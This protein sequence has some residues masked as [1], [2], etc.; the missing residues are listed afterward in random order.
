MFISF[1]FSGLKMNR[2]VAGIVSLAVVLSLTAMPGVHSSLD[3]NSKQTN[4]KINKAIAD[5][6]TLTRVMA[7]KKGNCAAPKPSYRAEML[8]AVER[9]YSTYP[10]GHTAKST[11]ACL[12]DAIQIP[13]PERAYTHLVI[14][15]LPDPVHTSLAL[16]FDRQIDALQQGAQDNGWIFDE[17]KMPWDNKDHPESSDPN[18]RKLAESYQGAAEEQPGFLMFHH[19]PKSDGT[20]SRERL[21]VFVVGETPTGGVEKQQF[22]NA[23]AI[24]QQ[25]F[26][27][28][29]KCSVKYPLGPLP[30]LGPTFS[31][32][33]ASLSQLLKC[34]GI[35][36]KINLACR[37]NISIFS[38]TVTDRLSV[39]AFNLT[40]GKN[41]LQTLQEFDANSIDRL[42]AFSQKRSYKMERIA[43]LSE[44]ETAYGAS[45]SFSQSRPPCCERNLENDVAHFYFPRE[46]SQLRNAYQHNLTAEPRRDKNQSTTLPLDLESNGSDDDTV[47]QYSRNQLPLSQESVLL[48]IVA[49][50]RKHNSELVIIRATDPFDQLFLARFLRQAYPQG[51]IITVGA[52]LLFS[53]EVQDARLHGVIALSTYDLTPG[54]GHELTPSGEF[55]SDRVFP[56]SYSMGTYNAM[57]LLLATIPLKDGDSFE[58][59]HASPACHSVLTARLMG[60]RDT[61]DDSSSERK[62]TRPAVHL[63]VLGHEGFW[64]LASLPATCDENLPPVCVPEAPSCAVIA[65]MARLP[66]DWQL[67]WLL[68]IFI[69]IAYAY[70]LWTASIF[71]TSE[72]VA[73]LAPPVSDSR[74]VLLASTG[75]L[76]F[77]LL[78]AVSLPYFFYKHHLQFFVLVLTMIVILM[79]CWADL[80]RRSA[81]RF[82]IFCFVVA[83][84]ATSIWIVLLWNSGSA[85]ELAVPRS[86]TLSSGVSPLLPLLLLLLGGLWSAWYSLSGASLVGSHCPI[87]PSSGDIEGSEIKSRKT[88]YPLLKDSQV[89]LKRL[90]NPAQWDSS[91]VVAAVL[92]ILACRNFA[93]T[94]PFRTLEGKGYEL[95]LAVLV[96]SILGFLVAGVIRLKGIWV[97]LHVLLESLNLLGLGSGFKRLTG[98][99]W[100]PL[101]RLSPGNRLVLRKLVT[102]QLETATKIDQLQ[103]HGFISFREELEKHEEKILNISYTA[104]QNSIKG[105][106]WQLLH[107]PKKW[108]LQIA[109]QSRLE[110]YLLEAYSGL[111]SALA[112]VTFQA[113]EYAVTHTADNIDNLNDEESSEKVVARAI[114]P[115]QSLPATAEEKLEAKA[116]EKRAERLQRCQELVALLYTNFM[117]VVLIRIRTLIFGIAG[118]YIFL[119]LALSV[120]P[121]QPQLGIRLSLMMLLAGIVVVV[122]TVYAQMHRDTILS[123]ITDTRPGELGADFWIQIITF[124]ALPLLSLVASQFPEISSGLTTWIEPALKALK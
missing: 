111:R 90:L 119:L 47:R 101:W 106:G 4:D 87:L 113:L 49:G 116:R 35:G 98:F 110:K 23:V 121:F 14:A 104:E 86:V 1:V 85:K 60:Y 107:A 19:I 57:A 66:K 118:M 96:T 95:T 46:I 10:G 77:A 21:L 54:A 79:V 81:P 5:S 18:T 20:V 52:D 103:I 32:S 29:S 83:C 59:A 67:F 42:L 117:I 68:A 51:R 99:A 63:S 71:S 74:K 123:Y 84:V 72:S 12:A 69:S 40:M 115:L 100:A 124:V 34:L 70:S 122:G 2:G 11:G 73:H 6:S 15:L 82:L 89:V 108:Y 80:V 38:G 9:R 41:K 22:Q 102:Q 37:N 28:K 92:V 78:A 65:P 53:R 30:I 27:G 62:P 105:S 50:L 109:E 25:L 26:C 58:Q 31:G 43:I 45:V 114:L 94:T 39:N 91:S 64:H 97:R 75:F 7:Q 3:S 48:G 36:A 61:P 24:T 76:H 56:S 33:L 8:Q 88:L 93:G 120:Y 16:F 112:R 17:A 44:D 13:Q 55:H